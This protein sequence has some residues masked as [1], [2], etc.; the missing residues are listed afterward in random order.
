[1]GDLNYYDNTS[2]NEKQFVELFVKRLQEILDKREMSHYQLSVRA[3]VSQS[4]ISTLFNRGSL[5]SFFSIARICQGL[6]MSIA[7]FF[8]EGFGPVNYK[9]PEVDELHTLLQLM[10]DE[11]K[12]ILVAY[13]KGYLG[14]V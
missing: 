5:P 2:T 11:D 8:A 4:T 10:T 3:N 9:A 14:R 6:D 1:M 7:D 13:M 12:Q